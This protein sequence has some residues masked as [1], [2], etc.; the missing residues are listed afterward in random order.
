M[1]EKDSGFRFTGWHALGVFGGAFAIII[2]VNLTMAYNAVSTFPGLETKNSYVASQTFDARRAAQT[3]LGW[4]VSATYADGSLRLTILDS[5]GNP[6]EALRLDATLGRA[7]HVKDDRH[8]D[9]VFDGKGYVAPESLA[10]G[11]W[12]IRMTATAR[13]GTPFTQRVPFYVSTRAAG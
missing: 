7:T 10:P 13:D 9:F 4:D 12:N 1:T 6:V 3:A 8:P 5:N 11:N 2:S